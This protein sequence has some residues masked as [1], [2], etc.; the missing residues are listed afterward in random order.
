MRRKKIIAIIAGTI[1]IIYSLIGFIAVPLILES[2]LPDK[3]SEALNRPVSINNIR[4]NPFALTAAVEGLNIKDKNPAAPFV[5]F[6]EL[7]V[8]IQTMSLLKL[9]LVV[10]EVRL[11][12]PHIHLARTSE[13][14]FNFSDLIPE[15]KPEP[16]PKPKTEDPETD[17]K[18]FRF[19][20]SNIAIIDGNISLEDEPVQKQ[21]VFS[22]INLTLPH[23]S[24]FDP[25]VD[26]YANPL[27][28]GDFNQAGIS[29][30]VNT[31]PFHDTL[32]TIVTLSFSGIAIPH[33]FAYVPEN[34]VGFEIH[35]GQL[36]VDARISY[37]QNNDQSEVTLQG[38][39]GLTDLEIS[40]KNGNELFTLPGLQ[41]DVAPSRPLEQQLTLASVKI[42]S[43]ELSISRNPDGIINLTTLGP[44]PPETAEASEDMQEESIE[45][46]SGP[47]ENVL[48][49]NTPE[50][51]FQLEISDFLLDSGKIIFTDY[52]VKKPADSPVELTV[53][54]LLI[55]L[56]E[57]SN[58]PD[59][60]AEY[61]IHALINKEADI[62]TTGQLGVTPLL[63]ETDFSLADLKLAWGQPYLPETIRLVIADG[64]FS[65]SGHAAVNTTAE[66]EI[67]T[68]VTGKAA[69][70]EFE[71]VDPD[72]KEP[73]VSWN[74]FSF[75]GIDVSTHPLAITTDKILLKDFK[76]Q[77]IVFNDGATNL[78]KIF[79]KSEPE[80]DADQ[81]PSEPET[82]ENQEKT[83]VVPVKIGEV[84]LDN[85]DFKFIDKNIKPHFSTRLN[86]SALRVTGLTSEDFKAAAL[87]AEG[88]IDEYAPIKIEGSLNPLKKDL[89][90]DITYS[91]TNMELSPLSPYTGKYIGRTIEKGKF[92]TDVKYKID[93]KEI[94]AQNRV[95]LDQF[96]LGQKVDSEDA[97]NLPV[98]LALS[99][100]KDR[101]GQINVTLPISGRTDD[102][103]FGFGKP[104]LNAIKNLVVKAATSP[105]DLSAPLSA[106]AKNSGT[107][108]LRQQQRKSMMSAQKSWMPL[109]N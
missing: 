106:A 13:T 9:G 44:K 29:I 69:I 93:K 94:S 87:K 52:A 17:K 65:T 72:R 88:K 18:P 56:S 8:N 79:I 26:K 95:L 46:K 102:P 5:S 33:Y 10:K 99:L 2:I 75:D 55:K 6:D 109:R 15:K 3:L 11:A 58:A 47:E 61:D 89:F 22:A 101:N 35:K 104:L 108:N 107:S 28:T 48:E 60:T 34:M 54:D 24:N 49:E 40:E 64:K 51:P 30:N 78:D 73:F 84:L 83:S 86:L 53:D 20:I 25:H 36:N 23:I 37:L 39:I 85:F 4:L 92:T 31:K 71:S 77:L 59:K 14:E 82:P 12:K 19:A 7:F 70:N 27:L 100:L 1:L 21:H 96:T 91:L 63:V 105:F 38:A 74:T 62:S 81:K 42:Q 32:E 80:A 103:D 67:K 97:L 90:L 43:P 66:G 50:K 45:E 16:K 76:N 41:I 57:F 98:G 68:T